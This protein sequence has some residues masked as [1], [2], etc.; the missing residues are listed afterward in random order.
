MA[1]PTAWANAMGGAKPYGGKRF[2]PS[3][4]VPP[5]GSGTRCGAPRREGEKPGACLPK[6]GPPNALEETWSRGETG[7]A[8]AGPR[9]RRG[10]VG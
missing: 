2:A 9:Q 5:T 8:E 7:T 3:V 6:K 4:A 10:G 1:D